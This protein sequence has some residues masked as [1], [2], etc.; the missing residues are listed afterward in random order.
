MYSTEALQFLDPFGNVNKVNYDSSCNN[1]LC[2]P[3]NPKLS[4]LVKLTDIIGD[5]K[6][7]RRAK[8]KI[9]SY[10]EV[11][12]TCNLGEVTRKVKDLP[13]IISISGDQFKEKENIPEELIINDKSNFY[14]LVLVTMFLKS[15][16]HFISIFRFSSSP[17]FLY[18]SLASRKTKIIKRPTY[19]GKLG[20]LVFI[21]K[22]MGSKVLHPA[23]AFEKGISSMD[24]EVDFRK[25]KEE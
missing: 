10:K 25:F 18:D 17:W 11:C 6:G 23:K 21:S 15:L 13:L 24:I 9:S 3:R 19:N 22:Q 16:D 5:N 4:S 12:F 7:I 20:F 2:A 8:I 14:M 1:P